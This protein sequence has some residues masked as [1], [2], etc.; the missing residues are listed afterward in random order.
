MREIKEGETILAR[1]IA[2]DEAWGEG[3]N[4]F[5][6]DEEFVQVGTWGYGAGKSL[7]AHVH[8][9]VERKVGWTQEVLYIRKGRLQAN[10]YDSSDCLAAELIVSAGD[11]LILLYGGHSYQI[12]EDGTQVLEFKNG[13]YPGAE[14]DRRRF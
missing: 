4:F 1:H 6:V 9:P 10:I 14:A 11:I 3:L 7:H 12:L 13:P 5:S 8:K 2:A